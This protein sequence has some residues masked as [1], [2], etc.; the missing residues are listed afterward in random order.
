MMCP[1]PVLI[2]VLVVSA[3]ILL[4]AGVLQA[5]DDG[6]IQPMSPKTGVLVSGAVDIQVWV[7]PETEWDKIEFLLD[8]TVIATTKPCVLSVKW[9]TTTVPDGDHKL[10]MLGTLKDGTVRDSRTVTVTVV[11]G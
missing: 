2:A 10:Q 11:N 1:K 9:D 8:G 3:F 5:C 6:W 7:K 4:L